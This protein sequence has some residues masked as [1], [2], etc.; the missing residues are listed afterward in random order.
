M[1]W[2]TV[3]RGIDAVLQSDVGRSAKAVQTA[4]LIRQADGY[5]WVRL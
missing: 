5:R 1:S 3:R 2:D 4:E